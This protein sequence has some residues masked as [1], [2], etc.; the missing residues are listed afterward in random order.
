MGRALNAGISDSTISL[1]RG[2]AGSWIVQLLLINLLTLVDL[3][4]IDSCC[5]PV[6]DILIAL[7]CPERA[8]T[9]TVYRSLSHPWTLGRTTHCDT[10]NLVSSLKSEQP[11]STSLDLELYS[12]IPRPQSSK[13]QTLHHLKALHNA[14]R[15]HLQAETALPRL[16]RGPHSS[17]PPTNRRPHF[18]IPTIRAHLCH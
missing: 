16:H 3:L 15:T 7:L 5:S 11:N 12:T 13:L 18:T 1:H 4:S 8:T 2:I 17:T 10:D 9:N 6:L 14:K